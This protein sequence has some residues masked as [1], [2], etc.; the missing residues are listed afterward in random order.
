ML[1]DHVILPGRMWAYRKMDMK[2]QVEKDSGSARRVAFAISCE[3]LN[4]KSCDRVRDGFTSV[5][6]AGGRH[7]KGLSRFPSLTEI[8]G[9]STR[10]CPLCAL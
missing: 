3:R 9:A 8:G 5:H 10:S 7:S 4:H 1:G 6:L 2:R